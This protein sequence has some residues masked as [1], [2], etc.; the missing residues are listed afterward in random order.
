M[1]SAS[2]Y[3][4]ELT[5]YVCIDRALLGPVLC[6]CNMLWSKILSITSQHNV[7]SSVERSVTGCTLQLV[8]GR[9]PVD[10]IEHKCVVHRNVLLGDELD[11]LLRCDS[12]QHSRHVVNIRIAVSSP[13]NTAPRKQWSHRQITRSSAAAYPL[14]PNRCLS[15]VC[16]AKLLQLLLL[17]A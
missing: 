16:S 6:S 1:G 17:R 15:R 10:S 2:S 8:G 12:A 4:N 13:A 14:P 3:P 11:G 5:E 7:E 9:G